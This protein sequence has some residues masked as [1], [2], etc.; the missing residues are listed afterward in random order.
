M[1]IM[2]FIHLNPLLSYTLYGYATISVNVGK[3]K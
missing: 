3:L 2:V 1:C